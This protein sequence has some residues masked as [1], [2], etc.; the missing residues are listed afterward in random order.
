M[1]PV[2]AEVLPL[3]PVLLPLPFDKLEPP[4]FVEPL[5]EPRALVAP[6]DEL[7]DEP[8]VVDAEVDPVEPVEEPLGD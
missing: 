1:E 6:V 3:L 5:L 4:L 2:V 8:P 7:L